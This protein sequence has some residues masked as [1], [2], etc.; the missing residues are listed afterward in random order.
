MFLGHLPSQQS[1]LTWY[2]CLFCSVCHYF[3]EFSEHVCFFLNWQRLTDDLDLILYTAVHVHIAFAVGLQWGLQRDFQALSIH[4]VSEFSQLVCSGDCKQTEKKRVCMPS[5]AV[6]LQLRLQ[7]GCTSSLFAVLWQLV[8]SWGLQRGCSSSL[9]A[10]GL[11]PN[12][13]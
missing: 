6:G 1:H 7:G 4:F 5:S 13:S 2:L 3:Q 9:F 11:Q 8:C 12:I 10:V